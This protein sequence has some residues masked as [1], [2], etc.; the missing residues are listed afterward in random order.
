[1]LFNGNSLS[2][3]SS[4]GKLSL[5]SANTISLG[6]RIEMSI[7]WVLPAWRLMQI[8]SR[9]DSSLIN[10]IDHIIS[11]LLAQNSSGLFILLNSL[12][13]FVFVAAYWY[14]V[15]SPELF[16]AQGMKSSGQR[17]LCDFTEDA[18]SCSH[19]ACQAPEMCN[20]ASIYKHVKGYFYQLFSFPVNNRL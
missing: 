8:Q 10:V 7:P 12:I 16:L 19:P 17:G 14:S 18:M 15:C 13:F 11:F 2:S 9:K 6:L 5:R 20:T 3:F 1:M 4:P